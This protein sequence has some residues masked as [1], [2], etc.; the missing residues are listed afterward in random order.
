M[1]E[2]KKVYPQGQKKAAGCQTF[3]DD[4]K[5]CPFQ[6]VQSERFHFSLGPELKHDLI[7]EYLPPT[8]FNREDSSEIQ[9]ID[10]P[11]YSYLNMVRKDILVV[12]VEKYQKTTWSKRGTNGFNFDLSFQKQ[13]RSRGNELAGFMEW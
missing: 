6:R 13:H 2:D 3:H 10:P 7:N 9:I 4:G 12:V 5:Y 8:P 1:T 11:S